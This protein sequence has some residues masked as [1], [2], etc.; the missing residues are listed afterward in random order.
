MLN[1]DTNCYHFEKIIFDKGLFDN[2]VDATYI[3]HLEGNGRY[4]DI[5]QQLTKYQ[6][7]KITYILFNLT[8]INILIIL[9][10]I[11]INIIILVII[12]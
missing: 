2:C 5:M 4:D 9:I 12:L 7:T 6:P 10:N 11:I 3:I 8:I 1:Y